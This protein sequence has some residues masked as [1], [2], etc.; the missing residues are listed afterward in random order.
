[1][2]HYLVLV[3]GQMNDCRGGRLVLAGV[4][5]LFS[6]IVSKNVKLSLLTVHETEHQ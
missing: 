1:M 5:C 3:P 2:G 6:K 4:M